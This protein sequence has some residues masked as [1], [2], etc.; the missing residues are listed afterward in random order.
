VP[1]TSDISYYKS[2]RGYYTWFRNQQIKLAKGP[3]DKPTGPTYLAALKKF[4]ELLELAN[5][6]TADQGNTVRLICDLYAQHLERN[7]KKAS[8]RIFLDTC[9]SAIE[10]FGDKT[11]AEFKVYH[12]TGWLEEMAKPRRDRKGRVGKWGETYQAMALRTLT[13]ALNWA[14]KQGLIT[15][16]CLDQKGVVR[17]GKRSRG[18]E[19]Y[20]PHAVYNKLI[21]TVSQNF[22]DMILLLHDTGCRPAEAYHVEGRYYR[23]AEKVIVYPGEP[24]PG[25]FV[26]KN[27]RRVGRDRVIYLN[28]E[29]VKVIERRVKLYPE[30]PVFRTKRG[31]RWSNEAVSI[32]LRWYAKRLSIDV[33]PTAYGFR[34]SFATDWLLSGGSIKVLADLIGTSVAMIEKHYGHLQVDKARMRAIM[35]DTMSG[36]GS[37]RK[38]AKP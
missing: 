25:E 1:P 27:A 36:R 26:W 15:R 3:D 29:L 5:A 35:L 33:A 2:R 19:A 31:R 10:R 28:D 8:L 20:I 9:T 30:G 21:G 14:K 18:E 22:R 11:L 13:C 16:H 34:H 12:V 37:A 17:R 6:D 4:T 7:G 38:E 24:R 32:A 23:P